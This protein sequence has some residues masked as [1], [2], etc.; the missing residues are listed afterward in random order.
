MLLIQKGSSTS[1]KKLKTFYT[2]IWRIYQRQML[3]NLLPL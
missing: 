2:I 1:D 3:C